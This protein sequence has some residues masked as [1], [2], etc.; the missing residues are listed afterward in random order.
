MQIHLWTRANFA[1]PLGRELLC[2][3]VTKLNMGAL[4]QVAHVVQ[5]GLARSNLDL[6]AIHIFTRLG[7]E[8]M[9]MWLCVVCS[10]PWLSNPKTRMCHFATLVTICCCSCAWSKLFLAFLDIIYVSSGI[11]SMS[12]SCS[13]FLEVRWMSWG[14][15]FCLFY[16]HEW[17]FR[18]F[19]L[20]NSTTG[21][22]RLADWWARCLI[23]I[24]WRWL[25]SCRQWI[26]FVIKASLFIF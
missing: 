13:L 24:A 12:C 19:M 22:F 16:W 6:T 1:L 23:L 2:L 8:W 21:H 14:F 20:Q 11:I 3:W 10:N 15:K 7:Y 25:R 5:Y 9:I 17:N 18:V 4:P 26:D